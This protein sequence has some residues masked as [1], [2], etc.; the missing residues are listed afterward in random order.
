MYL[1]S[2][3]DVPKASLTFDPKDTRQLSDT[4]LSR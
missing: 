1:D 3:M 4:R 2:E